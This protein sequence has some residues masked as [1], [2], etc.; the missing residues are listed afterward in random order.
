MP[1]TVRSFFAIDVPGP[2][3]SRMSKILALLRTRLNGDRVRW[4]AAENLHVTLRFLGDVSSHV[5]PDVVASVAKELA[6]TPAFECHL[7]ELRGFPT[8]RNPRVI[9]INL[10]AEGHLSELAEAVDR[11]VVAAGLSA[12]PRGFRAH[13]TLGRLRGHAH[14][15]L[16][17][18]FH[19]G[20][21]PL[22]VDRVTLFRSDLR[23]AGA[24][25]TP[26]ESIELGV[27]G[28]AQN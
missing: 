28:A 13:L 4:A 9:A 2:L 17:D 15:S 24:V 21:V 14:P 6:G 12:D 7:G 27:Q 23:S 5:L 25:Y 8:S 18:E 3:R 22:H 26:L 19:L 1:Q 20:G 16:H 10:D 11:G